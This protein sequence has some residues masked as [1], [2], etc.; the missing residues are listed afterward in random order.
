MILQ[1]L[2]NYY[3]RKPDLPREGFENKEIPF[4]IELNTN[5][6]AVQIED[7][8][9]PDGKKKRAKNYLIPQ[10]GFATEIA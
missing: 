9:P 7:T 8:R 5:G 3:R 4:V 1:A 10:A 2:Y 6:L